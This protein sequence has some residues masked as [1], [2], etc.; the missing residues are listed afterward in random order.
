MGNLTEDMTRLCAEMESMY[1]SR[2]TLCES[3]A[4]GAKAR[5]EEVRELCAYFA[6][7]LAHKAR[8]AYKTRL[9]ELNNLKQGVAGLRQDVRGDL[10]VIRRAWAGMRA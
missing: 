2:Q 5:Q 8:Q 6:G 10:A 3:L 1:E 4:E 9:A 7:A